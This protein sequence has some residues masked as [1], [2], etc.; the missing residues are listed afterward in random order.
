MRGPAIPPATRPDPPW[1]TDL[2]KGPVRRPSSRAPASRRS[3]KR[4]LATAVRGKQHP[5]PT[6][7]FL[8]Y[9]G[10]PARRASSHIRRQSRQGLSR[11]ASVRGPPA[12]RLLAPFAMFA[13]SQLGRKYGLSR[14][15][16]SLRPAEPPPPDLR[17]A[18]GYP[19]LLRRRRGP[20][21]AGLPLPPGRAASRRDAPAARRWR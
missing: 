14:A 10:I 1:K 7:G 8:E 5:R 16:C 11:F 4:K 19:A 2:P 6:R 15:P 18:A 13:I 9:F 17:T 12:P 3:K 21:E 20:A